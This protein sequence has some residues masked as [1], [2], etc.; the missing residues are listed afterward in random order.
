MKRTI[1]FA[2]FLSLAGPLLAADTNAKDEATGA[3][4]KL[5]QAGN[6][7]WKTVVEFGN[8]TGTTDGKTSKDGLVWFS[9]VFGDNT[10]LAVGQGGK[11][12]VKTQDHD[13]QSLA[14]LEAAAGSEPGP[15]RFLIRRL[16]NFKSPAAEAVEMAEKMKEVKKDGDTYSGELT[17]AGARELLSF[18]PRRANSP[19]PK[20]AK[21]SAKLWTKSG[22]LTKYELKLQGSMNFN[23]ED[24]DV[25]R[26]TTVEFKDVGATK[27]EVPE[28]AKKKLS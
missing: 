10:T 22:A 5:D 19:E 25:D 7:T 18:G 1:A 16:Q 23:G 12:A 8:F 20:N 14:E 24:R 4:K 15:G 11:W 26:T 13:W 21:G 2:L 6:Y 9:M 17:E 3:A 28:P 27:V